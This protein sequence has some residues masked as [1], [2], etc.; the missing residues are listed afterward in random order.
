MVIGR[1]LGF[2]RRNYHLSV[3]DKVSVVPCDVTEL[4]YRWTHMQVFAEMF[5]LEL[6]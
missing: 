4:S 3:L 1:F 6:L 5:N 2:S